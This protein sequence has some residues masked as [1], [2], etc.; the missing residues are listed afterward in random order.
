[1]YRGLIAF[2]VL[3]LSGPTVAKASPIEGS[4]QINSAA[5]SISGVSSILH[6]GD[7]EKGIDAFSIGDFDIALREFK[8]LAEQGHADSQYY[9]GAMYMVGPWLGTTRDLEAS[10]KWFKLAADQGNVL[11][12]DAL[13]SMYL[14]GIGVDR[15]YKAGIKWYKLAAEQ[16]LAR[17]QLKV[18][19]IYFNG[20]VTAQDYEASLKWFN[21][22]AE[23]GDAKAQF[24]LGQ[25]FRDGVGV[26]RD[27][28]AAINWFEL[29]AAQGNVIAQYNLGT[30]YLNYVGTSSHSKGKNMDRIYGY[31]WWILA[32]SNGHKPA[33]EGLKSLAKLMNQDQIEQASKLAYDCTAKGYENC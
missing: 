19:N 11:A 9:L 30:L 13:G 15:D 28:K 31:M 4:T 25:L 8:L 7:Y 26:T 24:K 17:A 14:E 20:K 33:K 16:G 32:A 23:Q 3:V 22:A 2:L 5:N 29:A 6:G 10:L 1:M 21:F 27:Y 12:F 18:A